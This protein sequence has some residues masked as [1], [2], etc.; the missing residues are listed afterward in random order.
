[1]A[2][3]EDDF[4]RVSFGGGR[5]HRRNLMD[6]AGG[7]THESQLFSPTGPERTHVGTPGWDS[8]PHTAPWPR[9]KGAGAPPGYFFFFAVGFLADF[10]AGFL[11]SSSPSS[12][13]PKSSVTSSSSR[14][15]SDSGMGM[16]STR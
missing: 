10:L 3:D 8:P 7:F 5:W 1:A 2:G 15:S 11:S 16:S 9:K 13:S 4:C 6:W 12:S 14:S